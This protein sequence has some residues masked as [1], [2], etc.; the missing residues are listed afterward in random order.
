V[1]GPP[2]LTLPGTQTNVEG[3]SIDPPLQIEADD[4][5]GDELTYVATGLP[6]DLNI[7]PT[8]GEISGTISYTASSGSPYVVHITVSDDGDPSKSVDG[9]FTWYVSDANGP[10]EVINPGNQSSYQGEFIMLQIE[11]SDPDGNPLIF[12]AKDL[13]PDLLIDPATGLITGELSPWSINESPYSVKVIVSD[14]YPDGRI[15]ISFSWIVRRNE[16]YLPLII[17]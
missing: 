5:D 11:A 6:S 14:G 1:N 16:I 2:S 12:V 13:P 17:R 8:T 9:D 15:D 4:P 3:D 10:P 7:D